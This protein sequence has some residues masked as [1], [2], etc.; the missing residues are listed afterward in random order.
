[1]IATILHI[2][3]LILKIIGITLGILIG[4]ILLVLCAALFV[5]MRY[6][7]EITRT[8]GEGK[9]PIEVTAKF[10]WL[11]YVINA[12][13]IYSSELKLK[14]RVLFITIFKIPSK[15]KKSKKNTGRRVKNKTGKR[16][17]N[18]DKSE[19][20]FKNKSE[21]KSR[22]KS[23]DNVTLEEKQKNISEY[24][25]KEEKN[26]SDDSKKNKKSEEIADKFE[27]NASI[28]A[29]H[30][31]QQTDNEEDTEQKLSIKEK[32][33]KIWDFFKNIP[34]TIGEI[35]DRIKSVS[36]NIEYYM[37]IL[38][39]DMF[40]AAFGLCKGELISIFS[41]IRPR[42]IKA[43]LIIGTGDPAA[44]GQLIAYYYAVLYPFFGS[45]VTVVGDFDNK[46]IEGTVFIKGKVKLFTF[47][48]AVIRIY[49]NKDIKSLLKLFKKEDE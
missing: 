3:L 8:E 11:L 32:L 18:K 47:L 49:F 21:K 5:P 12:V 10:S 48:K 2:I 28:E 36:E 7:M 30:F 20:S 44:T 17:K 26:N 13:V 27:K 23:T 1:M 40:K 45:D 15:R 24:V 33:I 34:Y 39:D 22:D 38:K 14:L 19:K 25:I 41:Y 9:P 46:R 35:C 31:S 43:D 16:S 6:R 42:T 37:D 29:D 4:I